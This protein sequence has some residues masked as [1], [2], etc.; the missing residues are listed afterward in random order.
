[1]ALRRLLLICHGETEGA[2]GIGF[3]GSTDLP[4]SAQGHEQMRRAGSRFGQR[5]VDGFVATSLK[6]SWQGATQ[7]S[8]GADVRLMSDFQEI[9]FGRWEGQ[10]REAVQAADPVLYQD[11]ESGADSFEFPNGETRADYRA[12]IQRGLEALEATGARSLAAI[13]DPGVIAEITRQLSGQSL[14][15]GVPG[16][17]ESVVLT[18]AAD[19]WMLGA[20]SSDPAGLE[21][22]AA[23]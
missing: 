9:H 13:L 11:W 3:L 23:A 18:R 5:P 20:H 16:P 15:E 22:D 21:N 19:G 1:M 2:P 7:V 10:T 12:R 14:A 8:R 17:G 6:R 4:L